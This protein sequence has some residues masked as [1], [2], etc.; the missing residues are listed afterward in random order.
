[1]Q[2][3]LAN[4]SSVLGLDSAPNDLTLLQITLRGVLVLVASVFMVRLGDRRSLAQKSA[5]DLV[6]I[7]IIASVLA[8]AINGSSPLFATIGGAFLLILLHRALARAILKWPVLG[9]LVKGQPV[10]LLQSGVFKKE[11]MHSQLVSEED[12]EEDMRLEAKT[13]D[14]TEIKTARLETSGDISFIKMRRSPD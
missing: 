13:E 1:M 7:V 3:F 5:S 12:F 9:R 10:V 4:L 14:K 8:R 2:A 6:L 11:A